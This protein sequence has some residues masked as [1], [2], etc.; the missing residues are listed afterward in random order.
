MSISDIEMWRQ[1]DAQRCVCGHV[2]SIHA[3]RERIAADLEFNACVNCRKA[4]RGLSGTLHMGC[5]YWFAAARIAR[6]GAS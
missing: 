3:R 2:Y 5:R 4:K 1:R 6:G